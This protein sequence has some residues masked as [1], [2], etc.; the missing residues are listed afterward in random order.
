MMKFEFNENYE[1]M[2]WFKIIKSL[3]TSWT[4]LRTRVCNKYT[5]KVNKFLIW[6]VYYNW[7]PCLLAR[8]RRTHLKLAGNSCAASVIVYFLY[9]ARIDITLTA[10][11]V[12]RACFTTLLITCVIAIKNTAVAGSSFSLPPSHSPSLFLSFL[13]LLHDRSAGQPDRDAHAIR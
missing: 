6:F 5:R 7:Y 4:F 12:Y 3:F 9:L 1:S 11:A 13:V 10:Q 2:K 8:T